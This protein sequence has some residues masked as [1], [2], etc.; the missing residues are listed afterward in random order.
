VN[1]ILAIRG[2]LLGKLGYDILDNE[3]YN[4]WTLAEFMALVDPSY[5][6]TS[7]GRNNEDAIVVERGIVKMVEEKNGSVSKKVRT[8]ER[9]RKKKR[10]AKHKEVAANGKVF[11]PRQSKTKKNPLFTTVGFGHHAHAVLEDPP[12][13]HYVLNAHWDGRPVRIYDIRC[14]KRIA[15]L[16]A[17]L[18]EKALK[19]DKGKKKKYDM[20]TVTETDIIGLFKGAVVHEIRDGIVSKTARSSIFS[21]DT[22]VVSVY[23]D[24]LA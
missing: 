16:N 23:S 18:M 10:E 2:I 3:N 13:Q 5:E 21:P 9:A 11:V 20:I 17:I 1:V 8:T 4:A 24:H 15:K 12:K 22:D 14:P 7:D 19:W 6:N